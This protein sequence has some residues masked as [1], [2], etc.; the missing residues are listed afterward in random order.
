VIKMA[1]SKRA[2][3]RMKI[4]SKAE[5]MAI[6]KATKLLYEAELMGIKRMREIMRAADKRC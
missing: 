1:I 2:R 4:S 5:A 3:A 6:K